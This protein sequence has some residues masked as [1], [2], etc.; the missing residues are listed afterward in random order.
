M[1]CRNCGFETYVLNIPCQSSGCQ[2]HCATGSYC[3]ACQSC[4]PQ[5][6][7]NLAKANRQNYEAQMEHYFQLKS[8]AQTL[9]IPFQD[10]KFYNLSNPS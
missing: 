9:G 7:A 3:P 6:T 5:L 2:N 1:K 4:I 10:R 8:I